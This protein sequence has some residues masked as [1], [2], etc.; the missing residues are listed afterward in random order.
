MQVSLVLEYYVECGVFSPLI[1]VIAL[2]Y[3]HI[4]ARKFAI[5]TIF[6]VDFFSVSIKMPEC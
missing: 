5:I 3:D 1:S 6:L 2:I 4:S